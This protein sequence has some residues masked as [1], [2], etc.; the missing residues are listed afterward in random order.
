[1]LSGH[2]QVQA[3]ARCG[4][5]G[6]G[7]GAGAGD[8]DGAV[9]GSSPALSLRIDNDILGNQDQG[10]SNGVR[11]SLASGDLADPPDVPAAGSGG[12]AR[13]HAKCR[14]PLTSWLA[15]RLRGL[16]P[17]GST[18]QNLTVSLSQAIFTPTDRNRADLIPSDRPY[19]AAFLLG[20]GYNARTEDRL[21]AS[22][23]Q[24]GIVGPSA[25]GQ[26]AQ[27]QIHKL[28]GDTPFLGWENQLHDEGVFSLAHERFRRHA[29]AAQ[30]AG[31]DG[32]RWDAVTRWGGAMGNLMTEANLGGEL[33]WGRGLP[34]DFG[35]TPTRAA[36]E[37]V[38]GGPRIQGPGSSKGS[39]F[40]GF[41]SVDARWVLRDIS[42]D[43]NTFRRSHRVEK[44]PLVADFGYG[45]ALTWGDWKIVLARIHRTREFKGQKALPVFG[46]FIVSRPLSF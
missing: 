29:S 18:Q 24:L 32:G 10:Y 22:Q 40:H 43:G 38:P 44:E 6:G 30:D 31:T 13:D 34:D 23:L 25:R 46:S 1:L 11:L 17:A 35:S 26:Q 7:E 33:R 27:N 5:G 9:A 2:V 45:L 42:L 28:T 21:Q 37:P 15:H 41:A 20:L 36:G 14:W 8:G 12:D 39:S 4:G 3:H 19:A 16:K